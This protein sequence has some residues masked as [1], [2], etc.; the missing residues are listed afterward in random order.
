[1][2]Y[3]DLIPLLLLAVVFWLLIIKPMRAR[4][5]QFAALRTM[6]D[7]LVAG[8]RVMISSGIFGTI[9]GLEDETVELEVAPNTIITVA[10]AAVSE[11]IVD[12]EAE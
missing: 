1:M 4:Q 12:E 11:L 7:A 6:Q 5:K 9:C 8:E 2:T 3:Q 10:R